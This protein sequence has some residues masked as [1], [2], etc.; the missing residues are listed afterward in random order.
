MTFFR[1]FAW[2]FFRLFIFSR[3]VF[4]PRKDEMAQSVPAAERQTAHSTPLTVC[5]ISVH[6]FYYITVIIKASNRAEILRIILRNIFFLNETIC[7]DPSLE[8]SRRDGSNEGP[9]YI[10]MEKYGE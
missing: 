1:F 9:Q 6:M 10:F 5:L 7:C 2:R 3:G 8:P 4:S